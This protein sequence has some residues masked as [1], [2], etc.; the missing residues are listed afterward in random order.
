MLL[1]PSLSEVLPP[2]VAVR[3]RLEKYGLRAK[4]SW[5]QNFLIDDRAY[6]SIV[7]AA[8]IGPGD[9]VLEIGAGLGTLTERL[10]R[11]GATVI[12]IERDRDMCAVLRG[13][14]SEWPGLLLCEENALRL[15]V[16]RLAEEHAD[17]YR[18]HS[19]FYRVNPLSW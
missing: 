13:E 17:L 8:Q 11:T 3:T 7:A 6:G 12:A 16:Q 15:D 19:R 18:E 9:V 14:L 2:V 4:K 5:G 1:P 10:L